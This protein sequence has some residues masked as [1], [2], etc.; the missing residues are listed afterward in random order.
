[1]WCP[2]WHD[3]KKRVDNYES[4]VWMENCLKVGLAF[5]RGY[6]WQ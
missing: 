4:D 3:M 6:E 5:G 2:F 1:M